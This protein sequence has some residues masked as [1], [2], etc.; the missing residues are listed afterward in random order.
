[1]PTFSFDI[2][3]IF[4]LLFYVAMLV[5]VIHAG[6]LAYHWLHF[7]ADKNKSWLG[8][9]IHLAVG[10]ILILVMASALFSM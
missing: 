5:F 8:I 3:T 7:G 2:Y 4:E 10:S 1:M 6:V 9:A